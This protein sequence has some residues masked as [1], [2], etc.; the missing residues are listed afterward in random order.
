MLHRLP[1]TRARLVRDARHHH[2][3]VLTDNGNGY[4][5]HAWRDLCAELDITHTRTRPYTPRTN[6]KVERFNRTLAD[7][8][9]YVRVYRRNTAREHALDRWLH[10]YN[11]HRSHTALGGNPPMS[12][13]NNLR[14][15][16]THLASE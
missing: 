16:T 14:P 12:R 5:S 4:T 11:H 1:A 6:G 8:W 7:E 2:R 13:V 15:G 3:T 10:L 9:A